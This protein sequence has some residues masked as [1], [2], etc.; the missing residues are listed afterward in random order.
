MLDGESWSHSMVSPYFQRIVDRI[1]SMEKFMAAEKFEE[2]KE[3]DPSP[4]LRSPDANYHVVHSLCKFIHM[5]FEFLRLVNSF[6]QV[7]FDGT[8]RLIDFIR[9][10]NSVSR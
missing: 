6:P 5:L 2:E 3:V 4:T 8:M 1:N 9:L 10:Y 7:A